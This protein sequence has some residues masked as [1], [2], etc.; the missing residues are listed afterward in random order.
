[1]EKSTYT[2]T[3]IFIGTHLIFKISKERNGPHTNRVRCKI[4]W[5]IWITITIAKATKITIFV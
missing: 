4:F 1:M 2:L 3:H 5:N